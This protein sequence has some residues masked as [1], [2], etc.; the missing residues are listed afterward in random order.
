[1]GFVIDERRIE[2]N[3][4]KIEVILKMQSPKTIKEV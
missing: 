3:S 2:A 4:K 1:L